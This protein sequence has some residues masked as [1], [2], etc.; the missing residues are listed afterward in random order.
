MTDHSLVPMA[1][2]AAGLDFQQLVLAILAASVEREVKTMQGAC[3]VI[4][5]PPPAAS[6]CRGC[7]PNGGQRADVGAPAESQLRRLKR[8]FWPV[9]L[10]ALGLAPTKA[11]SA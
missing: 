8:L 3:Y 10:V 5:H 1:A 6:R 4:S 2:R 11:R 9:L 7:Q